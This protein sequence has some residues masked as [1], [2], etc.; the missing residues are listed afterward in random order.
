MRIQNS[1]TG[2]IL[3][4]HLEPQELSTLFDAM[5]SKIFDDGQDIITQ[6]DEGD[7][8]YIVD[9]GE[10]EVFVSSVDENGRLH[11][12]NKVAHVNAGGC[13]GELALIYGTPRAATVRALGSVRCWCIDRDTYRR[14]LLSQTI[15]KRNLYESFL[16]RV[17]I[18]R[19]HCRFLFSSLFRS[20]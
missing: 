4:A 10:A 1:L 16:E 13:F 2:N 18:L 3:F 5:F 7:F 8:F 17:P 15:A 12:P 20:F 11:T 19:E 6:G 14:I 9:S